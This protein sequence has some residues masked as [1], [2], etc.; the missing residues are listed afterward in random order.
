MKLILTEGAFRLD[1][2]LFYFTTSTKAIKENR[3]SFT[4]FENGLVNRSNEKFEV[5]HNITF[6]P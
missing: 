5:K 2:I 4:A 1:F 6:S 3:F